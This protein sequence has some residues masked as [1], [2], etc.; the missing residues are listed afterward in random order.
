MEILPLAEDA[1][2]S[3]LAITRQVGSSDSRIEGQ[4]RL[5]TSDAFSSYIVRQLP[6]LRE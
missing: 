5:T 2:R 3:F 4:V 6:K 1:E